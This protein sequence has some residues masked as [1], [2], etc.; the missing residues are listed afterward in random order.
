MCTSNGSWVL[1]SGSGSVWP[2]AGELSSYA[3]GASELSPRLEG[4]E[5]S[6]LWVLDD[7]CDVDSHYR[8]L[9]LGEG[10]IVGPE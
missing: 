10:G 8:F 6:H 5:R 7:V 4:V 9:G 3:L 2:A 1:G